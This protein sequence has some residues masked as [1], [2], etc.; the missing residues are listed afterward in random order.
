MRGLF[1]LYKRSC[2]ILQKHRIK[3]P[4]QDKHQLDQDEVY[5]FIQ[6]GNEE[7]K[8][9]FHD[10]DE[11]YYDWNFPKECKCYIEKPIRFILVDGC[12]PKLW[13]LSIISDILTMFCWLDVFLLYWIWSDYIQLRRRT[14]IGH[15]KVYPQVNRQSTTNKCNRHERR[16]PLS[17]SNCRGRLD[18][19]RSSLAADWSAAEPH[20]RQ[21]H[22]SA[23]RRPGVTRTAITFAG[24]VM[25]T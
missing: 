23:G 12:S 10:Y 6:N 9:R 7:R 5:F 25:P 22:E 14:F 2:L 13:M 17:T 20:G 8:L 4:Q 18:G 19:P 11:I 16:A 21:L 3:F 15:Q 1:R 24:S